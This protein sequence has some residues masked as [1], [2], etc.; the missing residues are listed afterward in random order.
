MTEKDFARETH[1]K[2]E[3]KKKDFSSFF[4]FMFV[5]FVCFA[6]KIFFISTKL[7]EDKFYQRAV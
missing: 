1:E 7:N 5:S 2:N 6:G 4:L 3:K